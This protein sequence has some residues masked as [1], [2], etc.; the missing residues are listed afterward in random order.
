MVEL[1]G[2]EIFVGIPLSEQKA[3]GAV[4]LMVECIVRSCSEETSEMVELLGDEIFVGIPLS[5]KPSWGKQR[6][7]GF[8]W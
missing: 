7:G 2:D 5:K 4:F 6:W 1:L 3:M 8:P